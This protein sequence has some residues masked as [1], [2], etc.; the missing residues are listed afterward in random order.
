[1]SES[2]WEHTPQG[3]TYD[4]SCLSETR[5]DQPVGSWLGPAQNAVASKELFS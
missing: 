5:E 2:T 1:M 3:S 4:Y